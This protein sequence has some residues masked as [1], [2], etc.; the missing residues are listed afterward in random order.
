[1][2]EEGSSTPRRALGP[3]PDDAGDPPAGGRSGSRAFADDGPSPTSP[4]TGGG[5]RGR[6][7]LSP[8][9]PED[10]LDVDSSTP[11]PPP[12]PVL[13]DSEA[14][15]APAAGRRYSA[16]ME[17]GEVA[18]AAPRRSAVSA[19]SPSSALEP[20]LPPVVRPTAPPPVTIQGPKAPTLPP[21]PPITADA[22][23]TTAPALPTPPPVTASLRSGP[24]PTPFSAFPRSVATAPTAPSDAP[25]IVPPVRPASSEPSFFSRS[26]P[27]AAEAATPAEPVSRPG[28]APRQPRVPRERVVREKKVR[29]KKVREPK[30][31]AA[32][33]AEAPA[34]AAEV[35]AIGILRGRS[36]RPALIVI[37]AVAAVVVL[38][39]GV[40]WALT[41][42]STA[43]SGGP[44][45]SGTSEAQDPFVTAADL[46][47]LG[48]VTWVDPS[49]EAAGL[50]PLCLP[51][52]ADG[53]PE[54]QR[55]PARKISSSG[56]PNDVVVQVID[57]YPD[58]A[59]ATQ[60]YAARLVQA[61]SC[62][63]T[64]ALITGAN[65]ISGLADS[66]ELVRLTVQEQTDQFH[67]LLISRTG[68]SVSLIDVTTATA[69]TASDVSN[70]AAAALS[71]GCGGQLGTCPGSISVATSAPPAGNP[72][73]WLVP[74]DLPR[75]TPGAGRWG[76]TEPKT[77]LD[78]VG[79]LC[80]AINLKSVSG[81]QA[82]GQRTLLLAD[83]TNAPQG[84]GVDQVVYTF[85]DA[86][87][88]TNLAKKLDK[89]LTGCPGRA[90][91]ASVKEGPAV[92]GTGANAAKI[93]GSTYLVTQKTGTNTVV[94][95]VAVL[96]VDTRLV[97]LLANP[98][99]S[100]D[101]S[102]SE[103]V[104]VAVRAGQRAS[105]AS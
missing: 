72:F 98:S 77:T 25:I 73:G 92:K 26:Q 63:D 68:R 59:T 80:E 93:S 20:H 54:A 60:A 58:D 38:V 81:T 7:A 42:R 13:P 87:G 53:L 95:R 55:S 96:S 103:W 1:M 75:I 10:P 66:A 51:A 40:V 11:V 27:T 61:G 36:S 83:D 65:T 89:N 71:R 39:A 34:G 33:A 16:S 74:A 78:V 30:A 2:A 45:A 67:S 76:A 52:T 28:K 44:S 35:P 90:P 6:F 79:S 56:S 31:V 62:A 15:L 4:A 17:P 88:V 102:D 64:V 41:L 8:L 100:F 69:V 86:G 29:E 5:R 9:S 24:S 57:T 47:T 12:V 49:V 91:T 18:S 85:A 43:P 84:F 97:Y 37:A 101:F 3:L 82:V 21:P 19:N 32:V 105:Q 104:Q 46:G 23:A 14:G 48:G 22:A 94:F 99:T 70:V 50:R